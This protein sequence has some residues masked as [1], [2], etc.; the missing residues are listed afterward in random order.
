MAAAGRLI[1]CNENAAEA[2][3]LS[4]PQ[5]LAA[6]FARGPVDGERSFAR[7]KKEAAAM[8][9]LQSAHLGKKAGLKRVSQRRTEAYRSEDPCLGK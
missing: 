3:A 8:S 6:H 4:P 5:G 9:G 1:F 2:K 7:R